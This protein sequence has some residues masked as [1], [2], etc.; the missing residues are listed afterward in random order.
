MKAFFVAV[1]FIMAKAIALAETN[2][3][4]VR[5]W[6]SKRPFHDVRAMEF[7]DQGNLIL[8]EGMALVIY[9][10]DKN[11]IFY[12]FGNLH[13]SKIAYSQIYF[14]YI[15]GNSVLRHKIDIQSGSLENVDVLVSRKSGYKP[16]SLAVSHSGDV[17]LSDTTTT[18][19]QILRNTGER[20]QLDTGKSGPLMLSIGGDNL[21][22]AV[23]IKTSTVYVHNIKGNLLSSWKLNIEGKEFNGTID[24]MDVDKDGIVYIL[25]K[26]DSYY[27]MIS[28]E[29]KYLGKKEII[30]VQTQ[31]A[32]KPRIFSVSPQEQVF[33]LCDYPN[34]HARGYIIQIY[35]KDDSVDV[36]QGVGVDEKFPVNPEA[37][38]CLEDNNI[39]TPNCFK[40]IFYLYSSE[41]KWL[42][43]LSYPQ[44][45]VWG[46]RS[47]MARRGGGFYVPDLKGNLHLIDSNYQYEKSWEIRPSD[48]QEGGITIYMAQDADGLLYF[49]DEKKN[50]ILIFNQEGKLIRS[51]GNQENGKGKLNAPGGIGINSKGNLY[52]CDN[53]NRVAVFDKNGQFLFDWGGKSPENKPLMQPSYLKVDSKDRIWVVESFLSQVQV[54]DENGKFLFRFGKKG[55]GE[56]QFA[57]PCAIDFDRNNLIY[58]VD[59]EN[60]K[61]MV[62]KLNEQ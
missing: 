55:G 3:E 28:K 53:W 60:S 19:I 5:E 6:P 17:F 16:F 42:K 8:C 56:G 31:K 61:V 41:G 20:Q 45:N 44:F 30:D 54:F 37:L 9:D 58:I 52:V 26:K 23:D 32:L 49:S 29:G 34:E 25:N 51:F 27:I 12:N 43:N 40:P 7:D 22:Y 4:F 50:Q 47:L 24:E 36:W 15:E 38:A 11:C 62:F 46:I 1:V 39:I 35:N 18:R 10:K 33:V 57:V 13:T 48:F 14:Y 59:C 21:L 2:V